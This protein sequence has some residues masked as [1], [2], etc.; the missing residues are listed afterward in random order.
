MWLSGR[1]LVQETFLEAHLIL[2][3]VAQFLTLQEFSQSVVDPYS[4][5]A[6]SKPCC[7]VY[8]ERRKQVETG[9]KESAAM[10]RSSPLGRDTG[11]GGAHASS[12]L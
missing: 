8:R 12:P 5:D 4:T 10:G 7:K 11:V 9:T 1:V 6:L 2:G 3:I